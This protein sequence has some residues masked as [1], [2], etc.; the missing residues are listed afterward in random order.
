MS[1]TCEIISPSRSSKIIR[2]NGLIPFIEGSNDT[3]LEIV[4]S[5]NPRNSSSRRGRE[6][7]SEDGVIKEDPNGNVAQGG[8]ANIR[9]NFS[10]FPLNISKF[11]N[12][13]Y[14]SSYNENRSGSP[15]RNKTPLRHM[16]FG[17]DQSVYESSLFSN[18]SNTDDTISEETYHEK[19]KIFKSPANLDALDEMYKLDQV[20]IEIYSNTSAISKN[21]C[22]EPLKIKEISTFEFIE[23]SFKASLSLNDV[24]RRSFLIKETINY[25]AKSIE[26]FEDN[27]DIFAPVNK[28]A[29]RN[30]FV[31]SFNQET[32]QF[33]VSA[34]AGM[35]HNNKVLDMSWVSDDNS[36][37]VP[38][39][40]KSQTISDEIAES[41]Y[42]NINNN[43]IIE[44]YETNSV[45]VSNEY[46]KIFE[47][48]HSTGYTYDRSKVQG[49]DSIAFSG[50]ME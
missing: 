32:N 28:S 2:T 40:Q 27:V 26:F 24:R 16:S 42:I 22:I 29:I 33:S 9:P 30:K 6:E 41:E 25:N 34:I 38:Y 44:Y 39:Q 11:N 48:K 49:L 15:P 37:V 8:A 20:T 43:D 5:K 14:R 10:Y 19:E 35:T 23:N 4:E 13:K 18:F 21:G 36:Q 17:I 12:S 45:T 46:P 47:V 3:I 1:N 50:I 7:N 31:E